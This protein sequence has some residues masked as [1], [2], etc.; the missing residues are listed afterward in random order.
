MKQQIK[1][2]VLAALAFVS[3]CVLGF[4]EG[5][6]PEQK[7]RAEALR[8]TIP[9]DGQWQVAEGKM[10]APPIT[11]DHTVPVPG[12]VDMA[13]PAFEAVGVK[14]AKREAFWYRRTFK[15]EQPVPAVARLKLHKAMF[16]CK[17]WVN[18]KVVGEQKVAFTPVYCN[19]KDVLQQGE[20][21]VV[22][23]V[24]AWLPDGADSIG[25]DQ[26]KEKFIPGVFDSV[27]LILS[28][29][30]HIDRVQAVPDVEKQDV[31]IH[32]WPTQATHFIVREAYSGKIVGE[33]DGN[34]KVTIPMPGCRLWAPEDP[35]LYE[36]VVRTAGDELRARFGMRSFRLDPQTGHAV[37]NGKP[38]FMR[39]SN[40]AV[41]RFLEDAKRGGL[42]WDETWV[43]NFHRRCKAMHWNAL[44]YTIG[45]PPESWY[46]IA[47]EEGILIQDEFPIWMPHTKPGTLKVDELAGY[48]RDWMQ[49]RW[50]HPCVVIWDACNETS[51]PETGAALTK[52][53]DLDFSDRPWDN[54]YAYGKPMKKTDSLEQHAYHFFIDKLTTLEILGID[55][56]THDRKPGDNAVI[57]NEYGW[58]WLN[59]DGSPT[60]LTGG[61]YLNYLNPN[62]TAEDRLKMQ[63]RSGLVLQDILTHSTKEQRFTIQAR[64]LAADTEFWRAKRGT[65]AVMHFCAL[66][67]SRPK[68][69]FT[70]DN[71]ADVEKLEFEPLFYKY[72]R[73]AFAPVGLM[74]DNFV[75]EQLVGQEVDF[76]VVVFSDLDKPWKGMLRVTLTKEGKTLAEKTFPVALD[77]WGKTTQA[78]P[79]RM[80][81]ETGPCQVKATLLDTP[82][83]PV[84]SLRDFAVTTP[85]QQRARYGLAFGKPCTASSSDKQQFWADRKQF[86]M[87]MGPAAAVDRLLMTTWKPGSVDCPQWL[88]VDLQSPSKIS[89]VELTWKNKPAPDYS[90]QSSSDGKQWTEIY[91]AGGAQGNPQIVTFAATTCQWLRLYL[92]I[93]L[94]DK[95]PVELRDFKVFER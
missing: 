93:P 47:D 17:V 95:K 63:A 80:P 88:A 9:L 13:S 44:R 37:L 76:P 57:L 58:L 2:V 43:R 64:Y 31:T 55:P 84:S 23:R 86:W 32:A 34:D 12:L 6:K 52:V 4:A 65:A 22:I 66:G 30:Q 7:P 87:E 27:E 25:W 53:R 41:Y 14:S 71:W 42:P 83:G 78:C 1:T 50:N 48:Y 72:V 75:A 70:S 73:D 11:F 91:K 5:M 16:G 92:P 36:V 29:A 77:A 54:A 28:G 81:S 18:G 67:Y 35:F 20:N 94:V 62:A 56:G 24:G 74:V 8:S 3:S 60:R 90:I 49:E 39:G 40:A 15:V 79:L 59:R 46:R 85:E 19:V 21:E 82:D 10:E 38:Y 26:E 61:N 89:R 69:G 45:F 51:L 68:T 33:A